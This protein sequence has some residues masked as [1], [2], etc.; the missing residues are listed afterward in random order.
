GGTS[1][2]SALSRALEV[3]GKQ[4]GIARGAVALAGAPG[5][6]QIA[7]AYNAPTERVA[8]RYGL[9]DGV[10]SRVVSSNKPVVIPQGSR[11]RVMPGRS[12]R[13]PGRSRSGASATTTSPCA[14]CGSSPR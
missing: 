8:A 7:A 3:L 14:C 12:A 10:L 9:G 5:A 6:V 11:G 4:Y 1:L 13:S 2:K